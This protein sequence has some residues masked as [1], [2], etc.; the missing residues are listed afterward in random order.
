M[1]GLRQT[2]VVT[3][4]SLRSMP[5]RWVTAAVAAIG[6][7]GVVMV[8]VSVLSIGEGIKAILDNA[9]SDDVAIVLR[10]EAEQELNSFLPPDQLTAI[11]NSQSFARTETGPLISSE[12]SLFA[13]IPLRDAGTDAYVSFRGMSEHGPKLRAGFHIVKGRMFTTGKREFIVGEEA[14]RQFASL[15]VGS[16]VDIRGIDWTV[17]GVFADNGSVAESELWA[18][19]STLRDAYHFGQGANSVRAKLVD[20]NALSSLRDSLNTDPRLAVRVLT[21]RELYAEQSQ[22]LL[23]IV[24][25]AASIIA[26]LM[27][28]GAAFGALN[29]MYAAIAARTRE[30][31]T[32]RALG[33][34]AIPVIVSVVSEALL[35]GCI[36]G[37]A[38]GL[39]AYL[40]MDG[41]HFSTQNRGAIG[42]IGFAFAVT[43]P[44]I[45]Q[46]LLYALVLGMIGGL[47][48]C[49]RAAR[50][51]IARSLAAG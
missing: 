31:A 21:E 22:K 5:Q 3:A 27:G 39:L 40:A 20:A 30:I 2:L 4:T 32:L 43:P 35:L 14:L 7:A 17:V 44:L 51:P 10:R 12:S 29:T 47:L 8:L 15:D 6:I 28:I 34:G 38:G 46:G 19:N 50:L 9:G 25:T 33:F 11:A 36:G 41:F 48:P 1:N 24:R 23:G 42:Q 13:E 18:D 26:L 16:K 49:I 37:I 45:E